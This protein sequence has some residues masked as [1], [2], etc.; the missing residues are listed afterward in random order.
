L[1]GTIVTPAFAQEAGPFSGFRIEGIAGYDSL[2]AAD[3][4]DEDDNETLDGVSYGVGAGFD[5]DLGGIVAGIEAEYADSTAKES[6]KE[7]GEIATLKTGRDLYVGGRL[8]FR[9]GPATLIYGKGG[10][11][12]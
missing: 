7:A 2:R 1:P 4:E 3:S 9:A 11:P 10:T 5:F 6:E 12:I 8:G